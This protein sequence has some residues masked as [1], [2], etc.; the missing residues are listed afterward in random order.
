MG[1]LSPE[2]AKAWFP[3]KLAGAHSDTQ[4]S[5]R[6][7][8]KMC[9]QMRMDSR[10]VIARLEANG[11]YKVGQ[12]GSHAQFKH[13]TIKGRVTVPTPVKD[14]PAGTLRSIEKQSGF[15]F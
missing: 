13:P 4:Q 5:L 1:M 14:I 10:T 3:S 2:L 11:W 7:P 9:I 15:R 12:K 8:P 6:Q